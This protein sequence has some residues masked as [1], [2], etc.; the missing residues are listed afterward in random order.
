MTEAEVQ[1]LIDRQL[2]MER[3]ARAFDLAVENFHN[4]GRQSLVDYLESLVKAN[5]LPPAGGA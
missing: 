2:E 5:P 3:K 1:A 4:A